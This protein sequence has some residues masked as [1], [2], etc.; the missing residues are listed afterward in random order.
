MRRPTP[1]EPVKLTM[2]TCGEA[3]SASAASDPS[4]TTTLTTPGGKPASVNSSPSRTMA[5]GSCGAGLTTTV[6]PMARAGPIFPA[7]LVIGKLYEVMAATTPTGARRATPPMM[8]P[9][10]STVVGISPGGHGD[11]LLRG[12]PL[13]VAAEAGAGLGHLHLLGDPQGGAGLGLHQRHQLVVVLIDEVRHPVEQLGPVLRGGARPR[14]ER[15]RRGGGGG[16][17][18][19][20][21]RVGGVAHHLLGGGVDHGVRAVGG[22]HRLA[23]DEQ[24]IGGVGVGPH[25]RAGVAGVRVGGGHGANGSWSMRMALP[26]TSLRTVSSSRWPMSFWPTSRLWGHVLSEW[27]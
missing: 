19:G 22:V 25:R 21:R 7:V 13:G 5:S 27:G 8:P 16:L 23:A 17:G 6:L 4:P 3:T 18:V 11:G 2:S 26:R 15:G 24:A 20:G 14:G 12:D 10:A 9:G 1:V